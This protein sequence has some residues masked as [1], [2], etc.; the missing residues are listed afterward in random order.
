MSQF[1]KTGFSETI[2]PSKQESI[3][4]FSLHNDGV[5]ITLA[6]NWGKDWQISTI[7]HHP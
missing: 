7:P 1:S 5:N 2:Q 4:D 6:A 3:V